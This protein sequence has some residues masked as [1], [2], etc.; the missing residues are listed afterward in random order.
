MPE[1]D[2]TLFVRKLERKGQLAAADVEAILALPFSHK[3]VPPATYLVR[4][5][6]PPRNCAILLSGFAY[7]HKIVGDGGRQIVSLHLP[8]EA[9]DLQNLYLSYAD[10]NMQTLTQAELAVVPMTA[11]RSLLDERPAVSRAILLHML[12]EAAIMREWVTNIGRR[13]ARTRLAHLLCEFAV[14]LNGPEQTGS[15]YEV[16]MT[17]EQLGDALGLTSVHVN[18]LIRSFEAEGLISRSRRALRFADHPALREVGD[19]S[20][21]Y[22]HLDDQLILG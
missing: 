6:E 1:P 18:R 3:S 5:G 16:P 9:V 19:F 12:V 11:L 14:R 10:H 2:L 20:S 4:E 13:D 22:L 21:L 8:G 17:Q 15:L 7:R